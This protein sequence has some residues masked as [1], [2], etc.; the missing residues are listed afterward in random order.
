MARIH[1]RVEYQWDGEKYV[2]VREEGFEY[3]GP[4]AL[5]GGG[6]SQ[7]TQE[8]QQE[9]LSATQSQIN[10]DNTLQT[11]FTQQYQNQTNVLNYL[12]NT[13]K[14]II[15]NSE[16]GNGMS[17][18]AENAMRTSATDQLSSQYQSAQQALNATEAGQM[19]GNNV[20]PSGTEGQLDESL[21]NSEAQN[22]AAT[23]N[24]ITEYNQSLATSNLWNAINGLN[25]VSAQINPLGYASSAT[26]GTSAVASASGAQASLQNS[27]TNANNSG[28]MGSLMNGL[29]GNLAGAFTG[30]VGT[31]LP[32]ASGF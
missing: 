5:C 1:T 23:Q 9:D 13:L 3:F 28:F 2:V 17:Q 30:S 16:A 18:E 11:L 15:A 7:A 27:I 6:P 22:K 21:L 31:A 26:G 4:L 14:P 8:Q 25:G 12:Q 10:F 32:F 29:G 19:G 20:L 24:Q